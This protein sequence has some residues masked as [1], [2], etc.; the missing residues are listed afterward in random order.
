MKREYT[1]HLKMLDIGSIYVEDELSKGVVSEGTEKQIKQEC[2]T[3][4]KYIIDR[5]ANSGNS[6]MQKLKEIANDVI[7]DILEKPQVVF[8][9]EGVRSQGEILYSH[10]LNVC[11]MSVYIALKM[12]LNEKQV[13]EIAEGALIHDIGMQQIDLE[14]EHYRTGAYTEEEKREIRKH[15]AYGYSLVQE[16]EWLSKK[17]KDIILHHHERMDGS[18]FPMHLKGKKIALETA[19][20]AAC[21]ELDR[22]VYGHGRKKE[23]IHIALDYMRRQAG[24]LFQE[25]VVECMTKYMASYPNGTIVKLNTG[26]SGIVLRQDQRASNRPVV[27][28]LTRTDG[29]KYESWSEIVLGNETDVRI[30]DTVEYLLD[31]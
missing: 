21:D 26:D 5:F 22:R 3:K 24:V 30:V 28:L 25:A 9:M 6:E 2:Q 31:I 12:K 7:A 18:G 4:V 29:S 23:K 1:E 14:L 19:I 10:P 15:V 16:E 20:V 13:Y 27:R 8:M 11:A 17:V